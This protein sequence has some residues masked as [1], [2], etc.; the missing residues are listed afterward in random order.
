VYEVFVGDVQ[1]CADELDELLARARNRFGDEFELWVVGDLVNRGPK[2]LHALERVR[3][4][5]EAGRARY[6]LGNHELALIEIWMGLRA[7]R[8]VDTYGEVLASGERDDWME[9]L[10][11]RPLVA[12]GRIEGQDFAM[13][14]AAAH[15]DWTLAETERRAR[16][17]EA[18][19]GASEADAVHA[20]LA[21]DPRVDPDR[22]DLGRLT[23][24]RSADATG[25]WSSEVPAH[26]E[27]AWHRRWCA[28]QHGH[29]LVY[30]HW[31]VQGLHV[32]KGLRGLDTACVHH[33]RGRDGFL[34]AWIPAL[35]D[36]AGAQRQLP[37]D[38][39]DR[40]FWMVPA[41]RRYYGT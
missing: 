25:G 12:S 37:F 21:A 23:R 15:P 39:P 20:L 36:D 35:E 14:H 34:T 40:R 5:G 4:L 28:R 32:E 26:P 18:R 8:E 10:R 19:L 22:D 3:E 2:N 31:A 9:W 33:G 17:I 1:G 27:D 30:G 7:L 6:V 41:R 13:L 16:R 24:C 38:V 11:R 29:G